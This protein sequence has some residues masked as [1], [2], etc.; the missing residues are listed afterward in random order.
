MF[1][2]A[3]PFAST[4]FSGVGI[5]NV[6]VLINGKRFNIAIGNTAVSFSAQPSGNRF[7]LA[8]GTVNVVSWTNIDPNAGQTWVPIDP[9]N[10]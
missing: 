6:T 5:Q 10:P 9:L 4:T 3:T 7:N 2:G 8:N 1:F